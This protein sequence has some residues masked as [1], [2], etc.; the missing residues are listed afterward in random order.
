[1]RTD[2]CA[3]S[4]MSS[5]AASI[6]A[7]PLSG[8]CRGELL[9][10]V[11]VSSLRNHSW[12]LADAGKYIAGAVPSVKPFEGIDVRL[13]ACGGEPS[14][15]RQH[16]QAAAGTAASHFPVEIDIAAAHQHAGARGQPDTVA[17][18]Q[19][20]ELHGAQRPGRWTE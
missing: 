2:F 11:M 14:V 18:G 1:M 17:G 6:S 19:P 15:V 4:N 16:A 5:S 13:Q 3:R 12:H 10:G 8:V 7:L 20:A 9:S